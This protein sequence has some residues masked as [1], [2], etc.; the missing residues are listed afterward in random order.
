MDDSKET[1]Q[2]YLFNDYVKMQNFS[3]LKNP[4]N[5]IDYW[6]QNHGD[7]YVNILVSKKEEMEKVHLLNS[8]VPLENNK[9]IDLQQ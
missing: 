4:M 8:S 2:S 3:W 9:N 6:N 5:L 7:V 1:T